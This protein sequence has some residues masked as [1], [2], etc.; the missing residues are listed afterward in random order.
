MGG[1][2]AAYWSVATYVLGKFRTCRYYCCQHIGY[3][4]LSP[5]QSIFVAKN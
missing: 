5:K 1:Q 3:D 2:V 4:S